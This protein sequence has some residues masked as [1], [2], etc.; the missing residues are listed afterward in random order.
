MKVAIDFESV[1][2]NIQICR[3]GVYHGHRPAICFLII[4]MILILSTLTSVQVSE[5]RNVD[6]MQDRKSLPF[7]VRTVEHYDDEMETRG[8]RT[9][10]VVLND[11]EEAEL[12]RT[13]ALEPFGASSA[14]RALG[15]R[16]GAISV[17]DHKVHSTVAAVAK[18]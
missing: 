12:V 13:A 17:N 2:R 8:P 15:R 9:R 1:L 3:Q 5:R 18:S 7:T 4:V 10:A 6:V 16:W 14:V 11:G